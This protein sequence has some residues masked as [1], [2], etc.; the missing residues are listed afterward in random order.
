MKYLNR[1]GIVCGIASLLFITT[2]IFQSCGTK[3][4]T[5]GDIETIVEL[6]AEINELKAENSMLEGL[7][8]EL[9]DSTSDC[10]EV[11]AENEV[12]KRDNENYKIQ[13]EK[14]NY[15]FLNNYHASKSE[16][17]EDRKKQKLLHDNYIVRWTAC[18]QEKGNVQECYDLKENAERAS[19]RLDKLDDVIDGKYTLE[20]K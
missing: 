19:G 14:Q 12:L 7:V 3:P 6:K 17:N 2:A 18:V 5:G 4:P 9:Q 16:V 10:N 8:S 1:I 13:A 11:R 20:Q 15:I